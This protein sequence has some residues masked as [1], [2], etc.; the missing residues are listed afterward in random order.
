MINNLLKYAGILNPPKST[1]APDV[2]GKDNMIQ[3]TL[4][5]HIYRDLY[6][7]LDKDQIGAVLILGSITGYKWT[8]NSDI[9]VMVAVINPDDSMEKTKLT[10]SINGNKLQRTDHEVNYFIVE[11]SEDLL[12]GLKKSD[13]GVYHLFSPESLTPGAWLSAPG[14]PGL[15]R[16]PNNE[17]YLDI[18]LAQQKAREFERLVEDY[19]D[20]CQRATGFAANSDNLSAQAHYISLKNSKK[21]AYNALISFIHY[22]DSD[23]K[24]AYSIGFGIPRTSVENIVFKYIEHGPHADLVKDLKSAASELKK[25]KGWFFPK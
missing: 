17:F 16:D 4:K 5:A 22:L 24:E 7:I 10:A 25:G 20:I 3:P 9:D 2:W 8:P 14:D 23:R 11:Y 21:K 12:T 13:W 18:K 1:L 15:I 6:S 19:N